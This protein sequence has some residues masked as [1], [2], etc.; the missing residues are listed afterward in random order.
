MVKLSDIILMEDGTKITDIK[1]YKLKSCTFFCGVLKLEYAKPVHFKF[2]SES[3]ETILDE[4]YNLIPDI[5][6][7]FPTESYFALCGM[8]RNLISEKLSQICI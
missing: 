2:N 5:A 6:F 7:D 1:A 4:W 3:K 8:Y